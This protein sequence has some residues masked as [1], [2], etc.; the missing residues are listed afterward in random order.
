MESLSIGN[1]PRVIT[2]ILEADLADKVNAGDDVVIAGTIV[3]RWSPVFRGARCSVDIA[4]KANRY[5]KHMHNNCW[6]WC[7]VL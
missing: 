5:V 3:R 2:V 7:V 1:I 6:R 4:I